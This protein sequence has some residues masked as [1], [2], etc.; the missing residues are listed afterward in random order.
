MTSSA[1]I[2]RSELRSALAI[3]AKVVERRNNIPILSNVLL[4]ERMGCAVVRAT[5]L[6]IEATIL[7]PGASADPGFSTTIP[8]HTLKDVEKKAPATDHVAIDVPALPKSVAIDGRPKPGESIAEQNER[9]ARHRKAV[10]DYQARLDFE[11]LRVN[12]QALPTSDFPVMQIE[13]KIALALADLPTE[14]FRKAIEAV[15]LAISTE[16]T[17]YY[18]N[19]I[20]LHTVSTGGR[21]VLRMVATDGHRMARHDLCDLPEGSDSCGV[22]IPRKTVHFLHGLLKGKGAPETMSVTVNSSKAWFQI[23]HVFVVTKLID[24]AFPDYQRVT[25]SGNDKRLTIER[26]AFAKAIAAVSCISGE[27]GR[28]FKLAL[29]SG[30]NGWA[31]ATLT[32][33]NPDTGRTEMDV[34]CDWDSPPLETG[35]NASYMLEILAA[36]DGEVVEMK[37]ADPGSPALI[38]NPADGATIYVLM[39][40]RV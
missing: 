38:Y 18:L 36:M 30:P 35:F 31:K 16:E 10:A 5:D 4:M 32:V 24:G 27:R 7:L 29:D 33:N 25:P 34:E 37:L 19:G 23:G 26:E 11:G 13:G 9:L 40:M 14:V 2:V 6:D 20:Y 3:A 12:V 15:S 22:I 8:A 1:I 39:P 28:A 21:K 17:R